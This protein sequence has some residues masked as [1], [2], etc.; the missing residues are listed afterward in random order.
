VIRTE[1]VSAGSE[2]EFKASDAGNILVQALAND[3]FFELSWVYKP[4]AN[5]KEAKAAEGWKGFTT[6][7]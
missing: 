2:S 3:M 7:E 6:L 5:A 4:A 1:T